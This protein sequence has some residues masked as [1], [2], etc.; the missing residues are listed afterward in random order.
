MGA[1]PLEMDLAMTFGTQDFAGVGVLVT[2]ATSGLGEAAAAAFHELGARVAVLSRRLEAAK[3]AAG[4]LGERA[5]AFDADVTDAD[6]LDAAVTG[7][8]LAVDPLRV[9]VLCAGVAGW[10]RLVDS[11]G[12]PYPLAGFAEVIRVDLVGTFNSLRLAAAAMAGN[13]PDAGGERGV[14][15]MTSSIAAEDGQAGQCAYA[16]AKGGIDALTLAAARDLARLGIRV[17]TISPGVFRTPM[18]DGL[19]PGVLDRVTEHVA[20]PRRLGDP[21]EFARLACDIARN[22]YFNGEVIRLDGGLR[23]PIR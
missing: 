4:R 16:A 9:A 2:G 14:I 5:Y 10:G 1:H 17:C 6:R 3:E 7:A 19:R 20:F 15:I 13:E 23:M 11:A 22:R 8:R 12:R 18:T 21:A